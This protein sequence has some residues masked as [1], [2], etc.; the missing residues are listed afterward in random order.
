MGKGSPRGSDASALLQPSA[1]AVRNQARAIELFHLAFMQVVAARLRA[2]DYALKGGGN[3]RFFLRSGRRS[4]DLDLD[5]LGGNFTKFG[6]SVDT[7]L[8]G[9]TIPRLLR[10]RDI[11]MS[12]VRL[13]KNSD[14][15]KRWMLKLT[16]PGMPEATT[17][18]EFSDGGEG[19]T[20]VLGQVDADL[21]RQ[22]GGVAVRLNHYPAP[23][24]IA[25]KVGALCDRSQ[26]EPRD[27][28]DLDHLFRH[29]PDALVTV[30]LDRRSRQAAS[31][32]ENIT[33]ERYH[34]LVEP[35]LDETIVDLYSGQ[36]AWMDMRIRVIAAL[37]ERA[38]RV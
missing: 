34:E 16:R 21:A 11:T 33:Y 13:R 10:M 30:A 36:E 15:T 25:Q 2:Q 17:K 22:L 6:E 20:P 12:N 7:L 4:A 38:E 18:V 29:Y 37:R 26:T 27:V 3:L 9:E 1:D 23:V 28:F 14:T 24:A 19:A 31:I 8:A 5:Y 35:Y 32:A